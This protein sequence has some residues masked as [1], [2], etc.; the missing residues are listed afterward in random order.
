MKFIKKFIEMYN[1]NYTGGVINPNLLKIPVTQLKPKVEN[2]HI[3]NELYFYLI[4]SDF[5]RFK[6]TNSGGIGIK[7]LVLPAYDVQLLKTKAGSF[8]GV[9]IVVVTGDYM[10]RLSFTGRPILEMSG[11]AAFNKFIKVCKK[12]NV[13]LSKFEISTEEGKVQK[14]FI[15]KAKIEVTDYLEF[16]KTYENVH[17]IDYHN[18]YPAGLANHFPEL[19]EPIHYMYE[20]R[21]RTPVYKTVLNASIGYMQSPYSGYKYAHLSRAAIQDNNDRIDMLSS[22]VE[23]STD[24]ERH[25]LAYNTDGFW[26]NGSEFHGEGEG[27][28]LGQWHNDHVNC[29][30]RFK[31]KG[32]YEYIENGKYTP[33]LRG[34]CLLDK[35]KDRTEWEWGDIYDEDAQPV[36]FGF[37]IMK[38]VY[39]E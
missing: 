20:H 24:A 7:G 10:F 2:I 14:S 25:V 5:E 18:S 37:S 23:N 3:I 34:S 32:A 38:G 26:Y 15:P 28:D 1:I 6:R 31:S 39:Y 11:H 33:V 19:S 35:Y 13:D 29:T 17:H 36:K 27:N 12:F 4:S 9:E 16:D 21:K 22:M 30:I 8:N